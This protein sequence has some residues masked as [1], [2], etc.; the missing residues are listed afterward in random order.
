MEDSM[1]D[2]MKDVFEKAHEA[3]M[4]AVEELTVRPMIVV[5]GSREYFVADGACGFAWVTIR[6][7]NSKLARAAKQYAGARAA[8]NGGVQIRISQFNQSVAKKEA[9]AG[10]YAAALR[11]LTG[12]TRVY[13]GSR[14]D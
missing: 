13:A 11:G 6:P 8:Y 9:Y 1:K 4:R 12:E 5:D 7:G 2:S 10:A 3:G 14:L